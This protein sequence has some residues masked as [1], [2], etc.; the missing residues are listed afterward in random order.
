MFGSQVRLA[1]PFETSG[2]RGRPEARRLRGLDALRGLAALAVVLF[3]FGFGSSHQYGP[4]AQPAL[5]LVYGHLGVELFFIISGFVILR[6]LERCRGLGDFAVSRFSRLYPAYIA[7]ALLTVALMAA[8]RFNPHGLTVRDALM[9]AFMLSDLLGVTEIDYSYWTLQCE[10]LFYAAAALVY[11][12]LGIRRVEIPCLVWLAAMALGHVLHVD[13]H[14]FRLA[15]LFQTRSAN[16]FVIGMMIHRL[17]GADRSG[18][19]LATLAAAVALSLF[20]HWDAPARVLLPATVAFAALVWLASRER[21]GVLCIAPLLFL[22]DIS[23]SLYLIHQNVGEWLMLRL[24]TLGWNVNLAE[25]CALALV[26]GIATLV[27]HGVEIP[28]QGA[29][30]AAY[31]RLGGRS[32]ATEAAAMQ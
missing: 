8:A 23:Y 16:L 17:Q 18:L 30:R 19:T 26:I 14:H 15:M 12:G 28:A 31:R 27:R 10:V 13:V 32:H 5:L 22:G 7:C 3:H 6:T 4:S 9:N 2:E 11:F 25:L 1:A 24:R 20:P 29:I 21:L